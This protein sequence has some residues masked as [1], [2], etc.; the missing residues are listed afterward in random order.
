[1]G[2]PQIEVVVALAVDDLP[3]GVAVRMAGEGVDFDRDFFLKKPGEKPVHIGDAA[4]VL[5]ADRKEGRRVFEVLAGELCSEVA[6]A[7]DAEVSVFGAVFFESFEVA[8][9]VPK[10][11][12]TA[13]SALIIV[14][15]FVF[16]VF[17]KVNGFS[18]SLSEVTSVIGFPSASSG[19]VVS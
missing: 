3:A 17:V 5:A 2:D 18:I 11:F 19:F 16:L 10:S 14:F 15:P 8:V 7:V 6:R 9:L 1:M 13:L 12:F 4:E